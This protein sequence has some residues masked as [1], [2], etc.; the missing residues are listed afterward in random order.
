MILGILSGTL[1]ANHV[2]AAEE[3]KNKVLD[4][5]DGNMG[6]R[7]MTEDELLLQLNDE[8]TK[9]YKSLSPEGKRLAL[10]VASSRCNGTNSCKGLNACRDNK[11]DCAGKGQCKGQG[12]CAFSDPNDAVKVVSRK[13]AAKR[14][15]AQTK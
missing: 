2:C 10:E 9:L 1:M 13:M 12:I 4:A 14:T 15:Q 11:H 7:L 5:E 8:G 3:T 6:Y